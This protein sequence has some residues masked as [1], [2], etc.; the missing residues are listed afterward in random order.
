MKSFRHHPD[1]YIYINE[2]EMKLEDFLK[3]NPDYSLPQGFIG[4]DFV[5]GEYHRVYDSKDEEYLEV[6]Y[7]FGKKVVKDLKKYKR[8]VD[9]KNKRIKE[10]QDKK[11]REERERIERETIELNEKAQEEERERLEGLENDL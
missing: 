10:E 2:I 5:E 8:L 1:G 4:R 11:D 6:N 7:K 9:E 3:E